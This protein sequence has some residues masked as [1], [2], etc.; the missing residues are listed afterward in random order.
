MKKNIIFAAVA[1]AIGV[2]VAFVFAKQGQG[3]VLSVNQVS[4]DPAAF[5]GSITIT[6]IM[7]GVSQMDPS[8][9][10]IMDKKE[11]QCTTPNCNKVFIPIKY[12]GQQPVLGD[13]VKISGK[14]VNQAGGYLF[15]A[16]QL[17]VLRNHKIGG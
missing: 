14:F 12:Q 5:S 2:A 1:L 8:I 16:D 3:N 4:S 11:L 7:G 9:F 6:G 15:L 17:K 13:E 10:G